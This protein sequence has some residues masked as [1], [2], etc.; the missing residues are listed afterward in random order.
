MEK[1][2]SKQ[3]TLKCILNLKK[4]KVIQTEPAHLIG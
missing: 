4:K 2:S 3:K 1:Y